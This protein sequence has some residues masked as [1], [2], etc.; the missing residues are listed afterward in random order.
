MTYN[1]LRKGRFSAPANEYFI[2]TI[3]ANRNTIFS[4]LSL[5]RL[6]IQLL[7]DLE[8]PLQC[9]WLAWVLMPDHFHGLLRLDG[10]ISLAAVM[11]HIKGKSSRL[12]NQQQGCHGKVWQPGFYD[13]ALRHEE[14][15]LKV[16]RYIVANPLRAGLVNSIGSY[17]HWDC[18]WFSPST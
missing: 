4:D 5:A 7:R 1:V 8:H 14:D 10:D 12:I 11:R 16:A 13:H 17:P 15:R 9:R 6:F 18:I 2:T 3:C